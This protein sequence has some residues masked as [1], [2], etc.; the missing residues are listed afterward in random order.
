MVHTGNNVIYFK[1]PKSR[2]NILISYSI[3]TDQHWY[4]IQI[5][6]WV[7]CT[8]CVEYMYIKVDT[9]Q[10]LEQNKRPWILKKT[11]RTYRKIW[12]HYV[13]GR[14]AQI[15]ISKS[16]ILNLSVNKMHFCIKYTNYYLKYKKQIGS[17]IS[18][19]FSHFLPSFSFYFF[20]RGVV[21]S[22]QIGFI[23]IV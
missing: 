1:A 7:Q 22:A 11:D 15:I 13:V 3:P 9:Y 16:K 20:S 14:I 2:K 17:W 4:S 21:C 12:R 23:Y 8:I 10:Q 19:F 6:R 5:Y 18:H